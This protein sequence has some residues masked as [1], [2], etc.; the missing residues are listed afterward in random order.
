MGIILYCTY[1]YKS[2]RTQVRKSNLSTTVPFQ[3]AIAVL[4]TR[5]LMEISNSWGY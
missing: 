1:D 5:Q 4:V 2:L 3:T